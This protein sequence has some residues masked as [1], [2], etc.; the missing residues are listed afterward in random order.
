MAKGAMV[1]RDLIEEAQ[2]LGCVLV[3]SDFLLEGADG[4]HFVPRF[5]ERDGRRVALPPTNDDGEILDRL[6]VSNIKT[7]LGI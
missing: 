2:K 7:R 4:D 1:L 6:F 5:L 3:T